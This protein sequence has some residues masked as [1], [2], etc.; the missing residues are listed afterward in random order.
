MLKEV[1]AVAAFFDFEVSARFHDPLGQRS[2]GLSLK[3]SRE[4][5]SSGGGGP[6][7]G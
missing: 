4:F 3:L 6:G 2:H 7:S 5:L 1:I